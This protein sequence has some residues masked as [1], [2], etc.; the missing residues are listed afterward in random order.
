MWQIK[1]YKPI[2]R[3]LLKDGQT[4]TSRKSLLEFQKY[5]ESSWNFCLVD[6]V[7][8]NKFEIKKAREAN[9]SDIDEYIISQTDKLM[10]EQLKEIVADRKEKWLKINGVK[11]LI[12]IH[13]KRYNQ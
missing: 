6:W 1:Q 2:L 7:L 11:H 13:D 9:A 8:F 5:L 4:L 12:A 3:V 10:Q